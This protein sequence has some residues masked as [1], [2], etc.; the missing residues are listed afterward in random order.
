M[1]MTRRVTARR[2]PTILLAMGLVLTPGCYRGAEV[3]AGGTGDESGGTG[4]ESG[5]SGDEGEAPAERSSSPGVR[6]LTQREFVNAVRDLLGVT[7][8]RAQVPKEQLVEGHGH[9]ARGQG[10][11]LA[12]VE[13]Y[14]ELGLLA[15]EEAVALMEPGCELDTPACATMVA[16]DVL[17]RAFRQPLAPDVLDGYLS[18]LEAPEAGETTRERLVSLIATALASPHFLYRRELGDEPV[19]GSDYVRWLTEHELA[20]R[21]SFL[22]WQSGPDEAL[23]DAARAGELHDPEARAEHLLRML[24]D[25]RARVGQVGFAADWMGI[26]AG[27]TVADKDPEVL[28]GTS[29]QLPVL[30]EQSFERTVADV[31]F[32]EAGSFLGLLSTEQYWVEQQLAELLGLD[33]SGDELE[34]RPLD[35]SVRQ[36]MLMHPVVLA[37]HTKE[38]GA[39]PFPVGEFVYENMLCQTIGPP[40]ELP[41]VDTEPSEDQTLREQLETLTAAAECQAC[42][43]RIG[44]P[45]F[46]F[47]AFDPVG[48]YSAA[49]GLGRPFDT[50]GS[51]PVGEDMVG[52]ESAAEL[53]AAL[54][55]HPETARCVAHRLYR[56]T[57]GHF[58]AKD[59]A[60]Y[61]EQL[62]EASISTEADLREL[63]STIVRSDEFAQV[64]L[65]DQ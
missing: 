21:L 45:G 50:S 60:P 37:A 48:R 41:E 54:S 31:L 57:Y 4:A 10:V 6:L 3:E 33:P 42:H 32:D 56:W 51:I 40:L 7:L 59:T 34:A 9:I 26:G 47:L 29:P 18:I 55:V 52:F 2:T 11:G 14:Y 27:S 24:E 25:P 15:A 1:V 17:Q 12:E 39:S 43:T 49:D 58:E 61:L 13:R 30:A 22:V 38:S 20:S 53:S 19:E 16:E 65:G 46:A 23:L 62:S 36:G 63:L 8:D 64:R 44:P 28:E 5:E 35:T